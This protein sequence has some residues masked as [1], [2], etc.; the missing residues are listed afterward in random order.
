MDQY[1]SPSP[2]LRMGIRASK[3]ARP[4][5]SLGALLKVYLL[6]Q[7][8]SFFAQSGQ[9]IDVLFVPF[10]LS[11][12]WRLLSAGWAAVDASILA[13]PSAIFGFVEPRIISY[14]RPSA[15]ADLSLAIFPLSRI[16]LVV[17]CELSWTPFIYGTM[18]M[19]VVAPGATLRLGL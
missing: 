10:Y 16:S 11:A 4:G 3:A 5:F 9:Q 7:K 12:S 19:F 14:F 18:Q 13:G 6:E 15:G 2:S 17:G 1:L 8:Q